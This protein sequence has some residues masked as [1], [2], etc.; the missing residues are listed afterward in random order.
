MY[1]LIS[2]YCMPDNEDIAQFILI[3]IC[4]QAKGRQLNLIVTTPQAMRL[5][6]PAKLE[7]I[8]LIL[9]L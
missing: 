4:P 9:A 5:L 7:E 1:E 3:N 8:I 6:L 2:L